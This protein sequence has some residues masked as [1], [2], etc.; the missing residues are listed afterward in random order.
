MTQPIQSPFP[1][2][3]LR[4]GVIFAGTVITL[5]VGRE[6]SVALVRDLAKGSVVGVATQKAPAV[7][8]PGEGDLHPIGIF[9]RVVDLSRMPS[10]D[11]RVALEALG[12][13][14][15]GAIVRRDPY[16]LAEGAPAVETG[17][18]SEEARLFARALAEQVRA[19]S[20][21]GGALAELGNAEDDPGLFADR[22]AAALGLPTDKE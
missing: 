7:E 8:V 22:A 19:L 12:R 10:G 18:D 6:R 11:Y 5:P 13:L 4:N 14:A 21:G 15:I 17:G 3:P 2:L 16:W 9:A 20:K 1:L